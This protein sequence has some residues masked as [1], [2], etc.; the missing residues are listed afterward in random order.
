M[1]ANQI[2]QP[3]TLLPA[4]IEAIEKLSLRAFFQAAI[5]FGYD[6]FDI[7]YNSPDEV[8]D[9]AEDISREM[10]DR[11][12]GYNIGQRI[13]GNVDYRKA[14]YVILPDLQI[15]QALFVESKAEKEQGSARLQMSEVS[16]AVRQ[17]RWNKDVEERGQLGVV[18]RYEAV[19]YLTTILLAHYHYEDQDSHHI[20]RTLSLAAIP[21][22]KLQAT[23]NPDV[24]D[25][26]WGAGPNAE[27]EPFRVR[28]RLDLLA[29]KA[30]WRVQR[31]HYDAG[32]KQIEFAWEE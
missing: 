4:E 1:P 8:E 2:R 29:A 12:S 23:Y 32:T 11:L 22:G 7:F 31:I 18:Q 5:D 30:A 21:N 17:R 26:I 10:M 3:D 14:R 15:R 28:L 16:M 13:L 25:G 19:P 27:N 20:L 6:A 24:N 9:V